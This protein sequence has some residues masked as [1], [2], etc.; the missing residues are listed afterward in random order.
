MT[1]IRGNSMSSFSGPTVSSRNVYERFHNLE[2]GNRKG[3]KL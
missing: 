3:Q 1:T 2:Y